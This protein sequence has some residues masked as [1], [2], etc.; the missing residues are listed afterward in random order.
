M[1]RHPRFAP[2][3]RR[4]TDFTSGFGP[5]IREL[6]YARE[7][8]KCGSLE[9]PRGRRIYFGVVVADGTADGWTADSTFCTVHLSCENGFGVP[10][11][12]L[13]RVARYVRPEKSLV[14]PLLEH[15]RVFK[16]VPVCP[17]GHYSDA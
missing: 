10:A 6:R 15:R 8:E 16:P 3:R 13:D 12:L 1:S 7:S 5:R 4:Q 2:G 14:S 17:S 11:A 9:F